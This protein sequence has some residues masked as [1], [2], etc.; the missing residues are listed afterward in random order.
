MS[1]DLRSFLKQIE[2]REPNEVLH[3]KDRISP[4][5]EVT[6]VMQMLENQSRYPVLM[7]HDVLNLAGKGNNKLVTNL[8]ARRQ[9]LALALDLPLEKWK[10]E[11]TEEVAY[12][13]LGPYHPSSY[14]EQKHPLR[15]RCT[16]GTR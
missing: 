16:K 9:N 13:R 15:K 1:K 12:A 10:S 3:I 7:F 2:E 6:A 14:R 8:T 4:K 11:V 5:W